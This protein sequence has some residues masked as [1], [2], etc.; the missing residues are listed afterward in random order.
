M[1]FERFTHTGVKRTAKPVITIPSP[2][3]S[4]PRITL[5]AAA[6]DLLPDDTERLEFIIGTGEDEGTYGFMPTTT[7][8]RGSYKLR[9]DTRAFHSTIIVEM[10]D[11]PTTLRLPV[12]WDDDAR[13]LCFRIPQ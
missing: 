9:R 12:W 8:R 11:L 10:L 7:R 2:D 3:R 6:M 1:A 5:S 13:A 4:M